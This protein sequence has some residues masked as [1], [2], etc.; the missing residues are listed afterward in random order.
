[1]LASV[2]ACSG[3]PDLA[4]AAEPFAAAVARHFALLYAAGAGNSR[5]ADGKLQRGLSL[6]ELDAHVFMDALIEVIFAL[7]PVKCA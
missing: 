7:L 3:E 6:R 2:I 1:M 4:E 5:G